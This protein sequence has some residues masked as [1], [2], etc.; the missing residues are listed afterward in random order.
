MLEMVKIGKRSVNMVNVKYKLMYIFMVGL[1]SMVFYLNR[2]KFYNIEFF[3]YSILSLWLYYFFYTNKFVNLN[4]IIYISI[5]SLGVFPDRD[6]I[7]NNEIYIVILSLVLV[8]V[9]F[10]FG[11]IYQHRIK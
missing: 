3:I 7:Y 9:S 10:I 11:F 5:C 1:L 8:I 2:L 6:E 4:F